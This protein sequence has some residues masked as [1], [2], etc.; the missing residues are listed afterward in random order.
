MS[1]QVPTVHLAAFSSPGASATSWEQGRAE[2]AA[3]DVHWLSTVRR[4]NGHPHVTPLLAVWAAGAQYFCTGR[5]SARREIWHTTR[6]TGA[7][8]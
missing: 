4:P 7:L 3:A 2:L 8:A 5:Q 1:E 6:P